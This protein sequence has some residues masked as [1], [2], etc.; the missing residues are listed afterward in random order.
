MPIIFVHDG[1]ELDI[2]DL[3]LD[4]YIELEAS[5]SM[6]WH[7]LASN[8][9]RTAKGGSALAQACAAHLGIEL[10]PLTPRL[11]VDL[12]DMRPNE[13]NRPTQYQDGVP[14]P[15]AKGSDPETT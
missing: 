8:P 10:P 9:L 4:T 6:Q 2:D 3:P 15:K 14:D 1:H 12:F 11:L 13:P 5:T 7:Q